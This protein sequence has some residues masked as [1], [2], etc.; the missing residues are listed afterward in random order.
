MV[1]LLLLNV[2]AGAGIFLFQKPVLERKKAL[3]EEQRKELD[4]QVR[5]DANSVYRNGMRDLDTL[6]GMIPSKQQFAPLLGD[7][8]DTAKEC[9]VSTDSLTYKP[10]YLDQRN[11]LVYHVSLSVSG[12]YSA[13]RCYLYTMQTRKE[14]VVIDT[15]SMKN[16]D[17]YA[18][19]VSME[20]RLTAYLRDDA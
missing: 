19:N 14:L 1:V 4:V 17:P 9:H 13:I 18:E 6:R 16:E 10:E 3:V 12:R 15:I 7:F 2:I 8:M 20:L 11:L 5:G